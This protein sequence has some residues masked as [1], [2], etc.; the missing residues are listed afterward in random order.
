[1]A[2]EL[3]ALQEKLDC[4]VINKP[5]EVVPEA[6]MERATEHFEM[7]THDDI[8]EEE[9]QKDVV[10]IGEIFPKEVN[11]SNSLLG[12]SHGAQPLGGIDDMA[13]SEGMKAPTDEELRLTADG[14]GELQEVDDQNTTVSHNEDTS[15]LSSQ[16]LSDQIEGE[17]VMPSLV[18]DKR[19]DEAESMA[20]MEQNVKVMNDAEKNVG[21]VLRMD[22]NE[23]SLDHHQY[24]SVGGHPAGDCSEV[25]VLNPHSD[26]QVG[27]QAGQAPAALDEITIS[28]PYENGQTGDQ[29]ASDMELPMREDDIPNKTE[30]DKLEHIEMRIEVS[31]A[32]ENARDLAAELDSDRTTTEKEGAPHES[33]ALPGEQSNSN[34]D[35]NIQNESVTGKHEQETANEVEKVLEDAQHQPI[36]SSEMDN[37]PGRACDESAESPEE[38]SQSYHVE[39]IQ[40]ET[41]TEKNEQRT[42]DLNN[43]MAEGMLLD[44]FVL[45]PV[46]SSKLDNQGNELHA[47]GEATSIKMGEVSLP[48]SPNGHREMIDKDDL[49]SDREMDKKLV[50][51]N[52]KMREMVE[53]LME[54]G[55]EQI[56]IISKLSG[57]VKDLEKRLA[58]KKKQRRGCAMSVSKSRH[59]MLNGRIKA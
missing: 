30:A 59:P 32:E 56:A 4:M 22:M 52:E 11:E 44:L 12:E 29:S 24:S 35:L 58:R 53:K 18:G 37:Q 16:T 51:E 26:D 19:A 28:T 57:R 2:K 47:A 50:E 55:K 45:D 41:V 39:N 48:A 14:P 27:A 42:A 31:E 3:V 36:P 34:D 54:A 1:M 49:V 5:T 15:E 20:E 7:E 13:G 8:K 46:P 17:K 38:L 6:S 33:A 10:S 9:Q 40:N 25:H 43:K 23:E 21:E